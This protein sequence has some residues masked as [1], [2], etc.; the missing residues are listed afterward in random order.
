MLWSKACLSL[1]HSIAVAHSA[2]FVT[3]AIW[4]WCLHCTALLGTRGC[5]RRRVGGMGGAREAREREQDQESHQVGA[6][7]EAIQRERSPS[8]AARS[9]PGPGLGCCGDQVL[10]AYPSL[11]VS[12]CAGA[13]GALY[14]WA[15]SGAWTCVPH[16]VRLAGARAAPCG[17]ACILRAKQEHAMLASCSS[18]AAAPLCSSYGRGVLEPCARS[19]CRP[20]SGQPAC[21]RMQARQPACRGVESDLRTPHCAVLVCCCC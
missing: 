20:A 5:N 9:R 14:Y 16:R 12:F 2:T 21:K 7:C 11:L 3:L 15:C 6:G 13:A 8:R 1:L 10:H 18:M 17:H 4:Q 19:A